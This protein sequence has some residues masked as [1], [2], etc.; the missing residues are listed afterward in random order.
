MI[1]F[2]VLLIVLG[3]AAGAALPVQAGPRTKAA[4]EAAEYI[5]RKFGRKAV[6]EGSE[7]LARKIEVYAA[8]HGDD[9]ITAVRKVGP[10]AIPMVAEAGDHAGQAVRILAR[11]G[12]QGATW[13]VS[14]P[15]AMRMVLEHGDDAAAALVRHPGVAERVIEQAGNPAVKAL[16]AT[17]ARNGRRIAMLMEGELGKVPQRAELLEVIARYGDRAANFVWEHKGALA[18]GATL[19]AFVADPEPFLNGARDLAVIAGEHAVKPLAE[20]PGAVASEIARRTNWTPIFLVAMLIGVLAVIAWWRWPRPPVQG[21]H[22][23]MERRLGGIA[24]QS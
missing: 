5:M 24:P 11:H 10:R 16:Q 17:T 21:E 23:L 1:R 12:E 8:R 7:T 6:Q 19:T 22:S 4:Q 2:P 20:A 15:K 13:I 14:R 9:F 3:V 18:V